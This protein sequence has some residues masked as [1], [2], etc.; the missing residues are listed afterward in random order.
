MTVQ[1]S[2][3][4]R[5]AGGRLSAACLMPVL[6]LGL[7]LGLV[8]GTA[9]VAGASNSS[10]IAQARKKLL[11]LSDM[12]KGW[13]SS[14]SG[15]N[16]NS[17]PGAAQLARCLGVPVSVIKSSPP[18]AYSRQFTSKDQEVTVADNVSIY[19]SA[20]AARADFDIF[21]N[22]KA[23]NCLTTNYNGPGKAQMESETGAGKGLGTVEVSREPASDFAPHN[24]NYV[25]FF[26]IT[27][28]ETTLNVQLT[29]VD[30]IK[31][32]EEQTIGF[33]SFDTTL[34]TSLSR[35]LTAVADGRL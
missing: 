27:T 15:N 6:A 9:G 21:T 28:N 5:S 26:P 3:Q 24:A 2:R 22:P 32:N 25:L 1:R 13:T 35:H 18:T 29:V 19:P 12:P 4:F 7:A 11:V 33:T 14:K 8:A 31:G 10:Q 34:P 23:A 30:F 20:Q 17:T 16:N